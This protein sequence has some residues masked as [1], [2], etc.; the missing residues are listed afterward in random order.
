M[1]SW[2]LSSQV[3]DLNVS[4]EHTTA[5]V[6]KR[7]TWRTDVKLWALEA[8]QYAANGETWNPVVKQLPKERGGGRVRGQECI[9]HQ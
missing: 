9:N 7:P 2:E 6:Q 3:H 1:N 8:M 4:R 5:H